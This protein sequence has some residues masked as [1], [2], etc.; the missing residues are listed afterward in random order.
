MFYIVFDSVIHQV[1]QHFV[2]DLADAGD[3]L[4]DSFDFHRDVFFL[5]GVKKRITD[6]FCQFIEIYRLFLH[7]AGSL[8]QFGQLNDIL[9]QC[10]Q[11]VGFLMNT[12]CKFRDVCL[13]Y[14]AIFNQFRIARDRHQ[15]GF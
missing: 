7:L 11:S 2:Q 9:Y 12:G 15:R 3:F 5:G 4:G 14:H 13:L 6:I 8:F 10:G 1:V